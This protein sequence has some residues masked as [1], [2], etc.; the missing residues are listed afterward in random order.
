[1]SNGNFIWI[2]G[3]KLIKTVYMYMYDE[4]SK[5]NELNIKMQLLVNSILENIKWQFYW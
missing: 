3:Y 2:E 4:R 1:M 5:V